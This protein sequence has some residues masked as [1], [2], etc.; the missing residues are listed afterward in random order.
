[1]TAT[2]S[3]TLLLAAIYLGRKVYGLKND[4]LKRV[5]N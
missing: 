2:L 1:M 4:D 3:Y 5:W